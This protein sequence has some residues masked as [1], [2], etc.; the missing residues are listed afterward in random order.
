MSNAAAA[1][2]GRPPVTTRWQ[3]EDVALQLFDERGFARTTVDDV[4]AA[5]G[6]GRRTFFRYYRSKN[7][8]VWGDFEAGLEQLRT[9]LERVPP[10]SPLWDGLRT[11]VLAF[12]AID[13]AEEP[14]HRKRMQ[15][16]LQV[17]ALQAHSTLRYAAWRDVVAHHV[18]ERLSVP[19]EALLPQAVAHTALGACLAAYEQWLRRPGS[20]LPTL[21]DQSLD[22]LAQ[23]HRAL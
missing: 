7:D 14:R 5:A 17:P 10:V 11:E 19:P 22:C 12:N 2:L 21:L 8:V 13:A 18:A 20:H 6:I 1:R 4:A 23:G 3:L 16:I 9:R 15:L